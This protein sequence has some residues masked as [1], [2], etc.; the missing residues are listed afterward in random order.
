MEIDKIKI[1][2]QNDLKE[3]ISQLKKSNKLREVR[4]GFSNLIDNTS[5]LTR[6]KLGVHVGIYDD[7]IIVK[8]A[9]L[10][11]VVFLEE[12]IIIKEKIVDV[13]K[14]KINDVHYFFETPAK[15]GIAGNIKKRLNRHIESVIVKLK[16]GKFYELSRLFHQRPLLYSKR[17]EKFFWL[18]DPETEEF[19][20]HNERCFVSKKVN[21][22]E[23][24]L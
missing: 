23:D 1:A 24:K 2:A 18:K 20:V 12:G 22:V 14:I 8:P 17:P 6:N 13:G 3:Q 9:N 7:E 5:H 16:D 11:T 15:Y 19:T 21:L 10:A 4:I